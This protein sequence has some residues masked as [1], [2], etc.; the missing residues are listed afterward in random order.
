MQLLFPLYKIS[1]QKSRLY[2]GSGFQYTA[3]K[4]VCNLNKY[5]TF[6]LGLEEI[7]RT[8]ASNFRVRVLVFGEEHKLLFLNAAKLKS[9]FN[10]A[11]KL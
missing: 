7:Y 6:L 10:T 5:L 3:I 2:H 9:Y 8:S 4:G 11:S 1:N